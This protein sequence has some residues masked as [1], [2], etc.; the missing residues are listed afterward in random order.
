MRNGE[1]FDPSRHKH[2]V[3][4]PRQ[5]Y[6]RLS[7]R[8][9]KGFLN[10]ETMP[11]GRWMRHMRS[12]WQVNNGGVHEAHFAV[13]PPELVARMIRA[14][15][16]K[17]GIVL[18]PFVG[19]GTT[20]IV[21]EDKDCTGIGIDLNGNYLNMAAGRVLEARLKRANPTKSAKL[22]DLVGNP[23]GANADRGV[24]NCQ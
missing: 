9:V 14:G 6:V 7:E 12:V 19:S 16:P 11:N 22:A 5:A 21:A 3:N 2:D 20:V 1:K 18:D 13:W 8:I 4:D 10:R 17:G 23:A 15:C 24:P